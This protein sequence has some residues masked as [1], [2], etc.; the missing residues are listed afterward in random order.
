M[1][2]SPPLQRNGLVSRRWLL[3]CHRLPDAPN[4][5]SMVRICLHEPGTKRYRHGELGSA[6]TVK[7]DLYPVDPPPA[8][9]ATGE[10]LPRP[11]LFGCAESSG[12]S[13]QSL[14]VLPK[15][16]WFEW[17]NGP[18]GNALAFIAKGNDRAV[19][20][21]VDNLVLKLSVA[22]QTPEKKYAD[23]FPILVA[24]IHWQDQV[25]VHLFTVKG[26]CTTYPFHA[27]CQEKAILANRLLQERRVFRLP[28]ARVHWLRAVVPQLVRDNSQG[29][30]GANAT[31]PATS[32][33]PGSMC[34]PADHG[35]WK[36]LLEGD[37]RQH[38]ASTRLPRSAQHTLST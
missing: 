5:Q 2:R 9:P 7:W 29:L 19:Y 17:N 26:E 14:K 10:I 34:R 25:S 1:Q 24:K 18:V 37:R 15:R 8:E 11:G 12:A 33:L 28:M 23:A 20:D 16:L 4:H 35:L 6:P 13:S 21:A 3:H 32:I 27:A 36:R 38:N 31:G 30:R 22:S